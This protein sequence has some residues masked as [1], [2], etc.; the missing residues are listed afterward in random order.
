MKALL[1]WSCKLGILIG[2]CS[3][4]ASAERVVAPN[5]LSISFGEVIELTVPES[6]LDYLTYTMEVRGPNGYTLDKQ[7]SE[8][9]TF[10]WT[11]NDRNADGRY[12]IRF[13]PVFRF[14]KHI[15]LRLQ[16][17]RKSGDE[18]AMEAYRKE[19][20]IVGEATIYYANFLVLDGEPVNPWVS[21]EQQNP[22][23]FKPGNGSNLEDALLSAS[24]D[25]FVYQYFATGQNL[26]FV[27][28]QEKRLTAS[29]AAQV[30][31]SDVVITGSLCVGMDCVSSESFGFST[32]RMKENNLR[33]DFTDTSNS[34]SFPTTDWWVEANSSDNGGESYFMIQDR[35]SA[36][37][38]FTL[39]ANA[40]SYSLV[41]SEQGNL[42]VGTK[43][44]GGFEINV[45]DGDTPT[46]RL[47][48]NSS[49]GW[50]SQI[51]DVAGNE[52][53]F[54]IRNASDGSKLPFR[55]FPGARQNSLQLTASAIGMNN[56]LHLA[57]HVIPLADEALQQQVNPIR[58]V[59]PLINQLNPVS[60]T[61]SESD[62][63]E[64]LTLPQGVQYGL[65][66]QQ[67][68]QVLPDI[69]HRHELASAQEPSEHQL[70]GIDYDALIPFLIKAI[71]EQQEIIE[72]QGRRIQSLEEVLTT[73]AGAEASDQ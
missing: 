20:G 11:G 18:A 38:I 29:V 12:Q 31:T 69:V 66:A 56:D 51:W 47:S 70:K 21:E 65:S 6:D 63:S 36:R 7:P 57:G 53:N 10:E 71:Q 24:L 60:W 16:K 33:I 39:M 58:D 17:L 41:V 54:F 62:N 5:G 43:T 1:Q 67:V 9:L 72:L 13:M 27:D 46:L 73:F 3:V 59:L 64:A 48:Q 68:E 50:A 40:P 32:I 44:P 61:Y 22:S 14:E 55:I 34:S 8:G 45:E 19:L 23:F 2:L 42:G 37:E 30:F 52:T 26:E 28:E 25:E 49:Q 35:T 15:A 4:T